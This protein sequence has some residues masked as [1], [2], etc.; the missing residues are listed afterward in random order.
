M[1]MLALH[2]PWSKRLFWGIKRH[3]RRN[4]TSV[5][6]K[7]FSGDPT[8]P[9][10]HVRYVLSASRNPTENCGCHGRITESSPDSPDTAFRLPVMKNG[11]YK[12]PRCLSNWIYLQIC[13]N[14]HTYANHSPE[15]AG[16]RRLHVGA[17]RGSPSWSSWWVA[18]ALDS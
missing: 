10:K 4:P 9:I 11:N 6:P 15:K 17:P 3:K 7:I 8:Y 12:V 18:L 14:M 5:S 1:P 16:N 13:L 2:L